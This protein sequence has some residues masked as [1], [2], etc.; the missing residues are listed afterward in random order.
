MVG[1]G[2]SS[3]D[4]CDGSSSRGQEVGVVG[5]ATLR[6]GSALPD[7]LCVR[8]YVIP[9]RDELRASKII[10]TGRSRIAHQFV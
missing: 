9:R 6:G 10:K 3:C 8:V 5:V 2:V 7:A 1:R 4:T